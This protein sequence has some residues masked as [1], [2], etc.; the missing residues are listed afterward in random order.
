MQTIEIPGT[1]LQPSRIGLGT[2]SIGGWM[3]G[4]TEE[5]DA[6]R[7]I[8]EAID[9]GVTLIDTA[10]IY[11]FGASEVIVGKAL[12]GRGMRDKVVLATK[13]G[14]AWRSGGALPHRN[15]SA[16]RIL[17][18]VEDSLKRLRTEVID[19]YQVHWPD[20]ETSFEET[21]EAMKRLYD[22][23]KI[24]AIGVS[25]YAPE[26]MESFRAV[27]PLHTA[28]PPYNLFERGIEA[29]V[30]PYCKDHGITTLAYG[31]LCRSLLSGKLTAG[32]RFE[33][34][35]IRLVDPKFQAPRFAQYLAAVD[36]LD[37]FAQ[38]RYGKRVI[39]L[40]LR[41]LLDQPGVGI[42][43]W[44]ARR[45][46]QLEPAGEIWDFS[47]DRAAK[48]EIERIVADNVSEPL[49][50]EFMAPPLKRPAADA[51]TRGL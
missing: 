12:A 28:Q 3:W 48:D 13:C 23:G 42:A 16:K 4:G 26:Q 38:E 18:E 15:S 45:P 7:T 2:W 47:L 5:A 30:L 51:H 14:L 31:A 44:G 25:N 22:A 19:I 41:W 33:G 9:L 21:A 11:G 34:D 10:P 6:I 17:A 29:G 50:P 40:V 36:A 20:V 24:R 8:H 37:R 39:H 1:G 27:A 35:D 43:L 32:S 46:E 49:G